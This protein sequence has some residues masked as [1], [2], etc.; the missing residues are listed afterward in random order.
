MLLRHYLFNLT[1]LMF[2]FESVIH[3]TNPSSHRQHLWK[4]W[5]T[6]RNKIHFYYGLYFSN[7]FSCKQ[8]IPDQYWSLVLV[9][10]Q[11][12]RQKIYK[13]SDF[14]LF[15]HHKSKQ[16]VC[17]HWKNP[18]ATKVINSLSRLCIIRDLLDMNM[19]SRDRKETSTKGGVQ[20]LRFNLDIFLRKI[21]ENSCLI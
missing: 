7:F 6:I 10:L 13:C 8:I 1:R 11:T 2:F 4:S 5:I 12:F 14:W 9:A 18:H 21:K 3:S 16:D 19:F 15:L 20:L 17:L